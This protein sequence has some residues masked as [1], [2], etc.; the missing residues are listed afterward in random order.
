MGVTEAPT[1]EAALRPCSAVPVIA[2]SLLLASPPGQA[3]VPAPGTVWR[4]CDVCPE[5][6]SVP[7]GRFSMGSNPK[8][9]GRFGV[10]PDYAATEL[11]AHE[12]RIARP[13]AVGRFV[14]RLFGR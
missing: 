5:L 10:T 2:W 11:P 7:A 13:L 3:Q 8:E 1:P 9:Q 14:A 6:V 4:D 12:V